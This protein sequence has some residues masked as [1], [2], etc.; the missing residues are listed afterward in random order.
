MAYEQTT[1]MLKSV[2]LSEKDVEIYLYLLVHGQK[3]AASIA[4]TVE[5]P[6]WFVY[7]SLRRLR[8]KGMIFACHDR[9]WIYFAAPIDEVLKNKSRLIL[10]SATEITRSKKKLLRNWNEFLDETTS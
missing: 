6:L 2:G 9:A 4:Q 1:R 3:K 5:K 7:Q 10:D 8:S